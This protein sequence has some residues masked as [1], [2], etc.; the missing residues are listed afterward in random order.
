[1]TSSTPTTELEAVNILLGTIGE[2]PVNT[3]ESTGLVD[4]AAAKQLL[5]EVSREI[6]TKGWDFNSET[7]YPLPRAEDGTITVPT[8]TLRVDTTR[9]FKQYKVVQRGTRLY[10]KAKHSYVF[11]KTLM[12][13]IIFLLPFTELPEAARYYITIRAARRFQDR[14]LPSTLE[15]S[16]TEADEMAAMTTFKEAEGDTGDYNMFNG[17][18]SVASILER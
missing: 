5:A 10:D 6:Q 15:H 16:F 12:A 1:M 14:Y 17:S 4:V 9:A 13:E 11:D 2:A 7:D 3:L 18:Y 8:N